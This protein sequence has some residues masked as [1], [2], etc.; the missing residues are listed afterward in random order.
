MG[1]V[2]WGR[3]RRERSPDLAGNLEQNVAGWHPFEDRLH[4]RLKQS[5]DAGPR[6]SIIPPFERV[7]ARHQQVRGGGGIVQEERGRDRE[8]DLVERGPEPTLLRHRIQRVGFVHEKDIDLARRHG[9]LEVEESAVAVAGLNGSAELDGPTNVARHVVQNI[10]RRAQLGRPPVLEP[11]A[12]G[13][14]QRRL[15]GHKFIEQPPDL[16]GR[17]SGVLGNAVEPIGRQHRLEGRCISG[18]IRSGVDDRVGQAEG[19]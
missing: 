5:A 15:R 12:A 16:R 7:E 10:D 2:G 17:E 8:L 6:T 3:K 9:L 4:G 1:F 14:R 13:H 18:H 11:D 19:Q